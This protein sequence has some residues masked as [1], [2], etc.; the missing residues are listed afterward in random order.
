MTEKITGY[1]N[2][3]NAAK[4][5]VLDGTYSGRCKKEEKAAWVKVAQ[6][7]G[8][9][10]QELTRRLLNAEANHILNPEKCPD[11]DSSNFKRFFPSDAVG[12]TKC[13]DCG[14]D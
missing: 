8:L 13:Y 1:H 2:N 10:L 11:C 5:E 7:Q 9:T 6:S 4:K 14:R 3:K 12:N